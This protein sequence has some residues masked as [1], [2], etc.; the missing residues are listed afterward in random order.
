VEKQAYC[1]EILEG[2][3]RKVEVSNWKGEGYCRKAKNVPDELMVLDEKT[4]L[5]VSCFLKFSG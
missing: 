1:E 5:Q 3:K 4:I 2:L